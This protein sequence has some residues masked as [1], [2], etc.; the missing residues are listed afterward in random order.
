MPTDAK[1][2]KGDQQANSS[3]SY[4]ARV[5]L[6]GTT[7]MVDGRTGPLRPGMAVT[8]EIKTSSRRILEYLLSPLRHYS[9]EAIRE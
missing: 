8:A 4:V 5:V 9:R 2:G 6:E 7:M 1:N 3:P